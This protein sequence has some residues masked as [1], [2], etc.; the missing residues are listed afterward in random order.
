MYILTAEK[1]KIRIIKIFFSGKKA[2][3]NFYWWHN[4]TKMIIHLYR[5]FKIV[6]RSMRYCEE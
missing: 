4:N 3:Q 1:N 5:W 2:E 6:H